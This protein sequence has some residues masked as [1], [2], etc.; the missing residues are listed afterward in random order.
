[1]ILAATAL[2]LLAVAP[3]PPPAFRAGG[4][5]PAEAEALAA[6]AWED[7]AALL[8]AEGV[9]LPAAPRPVRLLPAAL[10]PA[11]AGQSRPGVIAL[12]PELPLSGAG[13][14]ALRHEVAH[15]LLL[16]ACPAA[17]GDRLFHEAFALAASGELASWAA[18]E[19]GQRY[20]P[21]ARAI[22]TLQAR[23][24]A[25]GA[26]PAALDTPAAR[27]AL[28]RLLA[29]TPARPGRL[30][31]ALARPLGRCEAGASW[32]PLRP[33]DLAAPEAPAGDAL[34]VLS[35]HG[36]EVLLAEGAARAPIPFGS[37]LKPFLLAGAPGPL[38]ALAPDPGRATWRC[39]PELPARVDAATALLRSCNGW[40]LDWAAR[41]PAVI[42]F[43][44]W[45]PA[46]RALGLSALPAD[47][48]EA[49]GV[50]PSLRLS[51][52]GLAQAYR[53]LAEARPDLV[54][55]L[56]RNAAEGTLSGL[57]ASPALRG[58]ALK[59]GTVL[60][61]A[62]N[63][64]L[65]LVAAVDRDVVVVMVRSGRT[66]RSFAGDLA[67]A[68]ARAR[69]PADGAARV[70]V[71]GL[72]D[73]AALEARCAGAGFAAAS[74]GPVATPAGFAPLAP[75]A[76]LGPLVCAGGGW[77]V[78][79]KGV[80]L[81]T[82]AGV[83]T[84]APP[85]P[86]RAPSPSTGTPATAREARARRGS[87]LVLRATRLGYAA[88]VVAAEADGLAGEARVALA[89]VADANG[90]SPA[91]RH[92]GRPACDTTHC[93]AFRGVAPVHPEDRAALSAPLAPGPW[94]PFSRGGSEPWS[95]E[96]TQAAVEAALGPG[97]RQ[98]A[99]GGGQVRFLASGGDP[100]APYEERR[101]RPCEALRGPLKLPACPTRAEARGVTVR[102]E[103]RGEGHGEG[104]D[105]EAA[106]RG[107]RSA[108]A[109][110]RQA[111]PDLAR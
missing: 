10:G 8:A 33:E 83:L 96:R 55:V 110:L 65:G 64:R 75:L 16:E 46:L 93:Q 38:P 98:L 68:L 91:G 36:G 22:G 89:R 85:A 56:S 107:G 108:D 44:R 50:K 77:E 53:L 73:P 111:Y 51:P 43:G 90:Q 12:R 3:A 34:V 102:F 6:R 20:L 100:A 48:A 109:L 71:L 72:V 60:D 21:L 97:A 31:P 92:P 32:L 103:G 82:Y 37:T 14:L 78:K 24:A 1:M 87:D 42:G 45:G 2:A 76:R 25:A 95:A 105:V 70:Q 19:E 58:V 79:G 63:P 29:E 17:A 84:W 40:F 18:A 41:S 9:A 80:P 54:D 13:G 5:L 7:Q 52:L 23:Q 15:Q 66:P 99:F 106:Q 47:G 49:I 94:R 59:T 74:A 35:R 30:P 57:P 28:A 26:N 61:A 104:L 4:G 39:G 81:R 67:A 88:G 101:S 11:E 62:A 86:A 69:T 27:R